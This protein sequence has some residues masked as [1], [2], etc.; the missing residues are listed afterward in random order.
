VKEKLKSPVPHK[1]IYILFPLTILLYWIFLTSQYQATRY[2]LPLIN[3]W[4]TLLP[5]FIFSLTANLKP[6][7]LKTVNLFF[8][9]ILILFPI[10][11][12][13][14]AILNR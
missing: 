5:L 1:F 6:A 4:Q 11:F 3:I 10:W 13:I 8:I 7:L 9:I 2:F 12:L 14:S